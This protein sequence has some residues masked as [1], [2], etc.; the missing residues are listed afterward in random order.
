MKAAAFVLLA[1]VASAA[2]AQTHY[3]SGYVTKNGVYVPP[4]YATNPNGTK[5]DNFSTQGNFNPYTG[6]AGK[7]NPY[8]PR[9]QFTPVYVQP[10]P[11]PTLQPVQPPARR[12][13]HGS[14]YQQPV[15]PMYQAPQQQF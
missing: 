12:L 2:M 14:I 5:L 7:V 6:Q 8:A 11:M 4:S 13:D 10:T 1:C 9:Q 3:R 15:A